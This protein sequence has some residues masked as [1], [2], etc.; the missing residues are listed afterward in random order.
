MKIKPS[1]YF[2]IAV[3]A[4]AL[5]LG[6]YSLTYSSMKLKLLPAII[7]GLVFVLS[8]IELR[9]ELITGQQAKGETEPEAEKTGV[10]ASSELRG[11]TLGFAWIL[12]FLLG[13]YFIGFLISIP[14]F[15]FSYLKLHGKNW[16]IS[17]TLAAGAIVLI[18]LVF[19]VAL[20]LNLFPG[21][22]FGGYF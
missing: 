1:T 3:I 16:L 12:G 10:G 7:S 18:Y 6:I 9:K 22:V 8:V 2:L 15:I 4:V 19:V 21:I 5:F 11:Y 17:V 14:L 20:K 13:I